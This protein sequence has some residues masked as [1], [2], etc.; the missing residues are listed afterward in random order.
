[1]TVAC[2]AF[3]IECLPGG[4]FAACASP[5]TAGALTDGP[6]TFTAR[7]RDAAGNLGSASATFT[8]DTTPPTVTILTRP[9]TPAATSTAT[10]TFTASEGAPQCKL[11]AGALTPCTSPATY[12]GLGDGAHTFTVQSADP[13]G[14]LGAATY[15]WTI[16]TTGPTL[17]FTQAPPAQWPVNYFVATWTANEPAT[18]ECR[19]DSGTSP[20]VFEPCETPFSFTTSYGAA[21]L[22]VHGVDALGN[23]G[24]DTAVS[25]TSTQG[26]VL[27]YAWEQ[28]STANSSLLAQIPAL[29]PDGRGSVPVVGGWAGTAAGAPERVLFVGT[30]RALASAPT[31]AYTASAWIRPAA[32]ATGTLWSTQNGTTGGHTVTING[33][34]VTLTLYEGGL[35]YSISKSVPFNQWSSVAVVT[36]DQGSGARLFIDGVPNDP[37][38]PPNENGFGLRAGDLSVG[39]L[40]NTDLDDLRFYNT[41]PDLCTTVLRGVLDLA[42]A[43]IET[44]PI[45]E[46]DFEHGITINTGTSTAGF[47]RPLG[48][49]FGSLHTGAALLLGGIPP[50]GPS[51]IDGPSYGHTISLWVAGPSPADTLVDLRQPCAATF[52]NGTCGVSIAW[53]AARQFSVFTGTPGTT[54]ATQI[55]TVVPPTPLSA[56]TGHSVVIT[57]D[58]ISNVVQIFVDGLLHARFPV[59]EGLY[60]RPTPMRMT[61]V[62]GVMIDE[63][64]LWPSDLSRTPEI[65]CENGFDGLWDPATNSCA[66]TSN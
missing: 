2:G 50:W 58:P 54:S 12:T 3:A 35:A 28:G 42:G 29:S 55:T 6:H 63:V 33:P 21:R 17:T 10:F 51:S 30:R 23:V 44:S 8:V 59:A 57:Q 22:V 26:L 38:R 25:W 65:L 37:V 31:G 15:T 9:A 34:I 62:N 43:C 48:A 19:I 5:F 52:S 40:T 60:A 20:P 36:T 16:D 49:S 27:H 32:G 18:Y 4:A 56:A 61:T 7:A 41:N 64:E 11:D 13:A 46:L 53:T 45:I 1:L 39:P 24:P 14:N 66:L 47:T